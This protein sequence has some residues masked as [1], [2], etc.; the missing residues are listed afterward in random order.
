MGMCVELCL[1]KVLTLTAPKTAMEAFLFLKMHFSLNSFSEKEV[2][3]FI[4]LMQHDKKNKNGQL[5]FAL[6][7]DVAKPLINIFASAKDVKE[8]FALYNN[9]LA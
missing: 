4:A 5:C 6:I 3:L 1:G 2:E 9:L 8:A 7:E